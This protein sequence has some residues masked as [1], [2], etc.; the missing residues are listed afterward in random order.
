MLFTG[1]I[2]IVPGLTYTIPV[3]AAAT[4]GE[5]GVDTRARTSRARS[6]PLRRSRLERRPCLVLMTIQLYGL[7]FSLKTLSAP[8]KVDVSLGAGEPLTVLVFN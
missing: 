6:V 1:E 8:C 5:R 7:D 4:I 2:G 3:P